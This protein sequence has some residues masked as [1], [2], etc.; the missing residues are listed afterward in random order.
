[1]KRLVLFVGAVLVVAIIFFGQ[2]SQQTTNKVSPSS[3]SGMMAADFQLKDLHGQELTLSSLRG[4]VVVLN[5]WATWCPP[6]REEMPSMEKLHHLM[7]GQPFVL[8]AVNIEENGPQAVR[9]FLQ[10][11][12]VT[13][14][15]LF[16]QSAE[17]RKRYGVSKYPETFI[18]NPE[19]EIV[20]KVVGAM[21][22]SQPRVLQYLKNLLAAPAK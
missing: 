13:F 5:F 8:L 22:W 17:V 18:I 20:E 2:A 9:S 21:D 14:P 1:M 3:A 15:I 19:G 6:C 12:H 7:Q 10:T 16:D 4:K 11:H